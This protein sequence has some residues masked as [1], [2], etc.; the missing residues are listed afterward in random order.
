M[1][2]SY[3]NKGRI[4]FLQIMQETKKEKKEHAAK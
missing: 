1:T 2:T 4:K 3:F